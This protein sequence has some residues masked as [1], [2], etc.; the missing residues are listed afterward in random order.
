MVRSLERRIARLEAPRV[1]LARTAARTYAMLW[2]CYAVLSRLDGDPMPIDA[3]L[4]AMAQVEA[5]S[6]S[7]PDYM[8]ALQAAWEDQDDP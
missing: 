8:A 4:R 6:G 5:L 1:D 7:P 3:E 2:A